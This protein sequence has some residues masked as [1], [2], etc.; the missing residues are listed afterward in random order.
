MG[1]IWGSIFTS[2]RSRDRTGQP[3]M[4]RPGLT[5]IQNFQPAQ[6][7][8]NGLETTAPRSSSTVNRKM[9]QTVEG[10]PAVMC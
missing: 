3:K 10:T 9:Q 7:N 1:R 2:Y 6:L 4:K 8:R 5:D